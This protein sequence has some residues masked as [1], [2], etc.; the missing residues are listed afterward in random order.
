MLRIDLV[1]ENG[2]CKLYWSKAQALLFL[3]PSATRYEGHIPMREINNHW[4]RYCICTMSDY[5]IKLE[6]T[7]R[8]YNEGM[9]TGEGHHCV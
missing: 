8:K 7:G 1:R 6:N 5:I 9:E 3:S 2:N 4:K